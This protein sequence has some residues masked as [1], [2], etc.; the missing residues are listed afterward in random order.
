MSRHTRFARAAFAIGLAAALG[1]RPAEAQLR[2]SQDRALTA[3]DGTA[4]VVTSGIVR[5]PE[6]CAVKRR[7]A[8]STWPWSACGALMRQPGARPMDEE[9]ITLPPIPFQK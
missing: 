2:D 3:Q 7:P 9:R 1:A 8:R 6:K 5:V 4:F